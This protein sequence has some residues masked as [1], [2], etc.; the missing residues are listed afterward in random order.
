MLQPL[1]LTAVT[2]RELRAV[3]GGLATLRDEVGRVAGPQAAEPRPAP[4]PVAL[5]AAAAAAVVALPLAVAG[6][7]ALSTLDGQ[8]W[9]WAGVAALLSAAARLVSGRAL[10]V[11]V[12]RRL[13]TARATVADVL[14]AGRGRPPV[15]AV[16]YLSRLAVP[17]GEAVPALHRLLVANRG[18]RVAA[19]G[20]AAAWLALGGSVS[21]RGPELPA[22]LL[23]AAAAAVL[24]A[25]GRRWPRTG[26]GPAAS[27]PGRPYGRLVGPV[28]LAV[29][30]EAIAFGAVADAA[31]TGL[32][33]QT[34]AGLYL[35]VALPA[36]LLVPAGLPE[37]LLFLALSAAGVPPAAA[38]LA[39]VAGR[40]ITYWL[41]AGVAAAA[42]LAGRRR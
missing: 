7:A 24:F 29:A 26:A 17:P 22:G 33:T 35:M 30:L 4:G 32:P 21:W 20:A 8:W 37:G 39:A 14:A 6:T 19:A 42:E 16:R 5:T 18:V 38:C 1:A 36:A 40:L 9:R 2:R 27:G 23:V 3:P 11:A 13:S 12:G 25:A 10:A 41:P 15:A 31:G 34:A 28:M